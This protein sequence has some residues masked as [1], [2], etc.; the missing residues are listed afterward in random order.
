M[1]EY[2]ISSGLLCISSFFIGLMWFS[3][4]KANLNKATTNLIAAKLALT[5]FGLVFQSACLFVITLSRSY[6]VLA[7][8]NMDVVVSLGMFGL[9][10]SDFLLILAASLNTNRRLYLI[11]YIGVCIVW[12]A[13]NAVIWAI[14]KGIF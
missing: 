11:I 2:F 10:F 13:G 1:N 9:V 14:T 4:I 3:L 6:E 8:F 5:A 7:G 12:L